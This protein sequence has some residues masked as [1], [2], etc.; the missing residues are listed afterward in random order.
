MNEERDTRDEP[1]TSFV[2]T[3]VGGTIHN[4][5]HCNK[6]TRANAHDHTHVR[7]TSLMI[8]KE[9]WSCCESQNQRVRFSAPSRH[10]QSDISLL[11]HATL[12]TQREMGCALERI[13][14]L[15]A[16]LIQQT[17]TQP[18]CSPRACSDYRF[19]RVSCTHKTRNGRGSAY[20]SPSIVN[21]GS[22]RPA[23]RPTMH[24]KKGLRDA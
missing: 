7:C 14:Q 1:R 10:M 24:P 5:V 3:A 6:W 17:H 13:L 15:D 20:V 18:L 19:V 23:W 11:T 9:R 4:G 8:Y 2:L 22:R 16:P 12:R 21:E